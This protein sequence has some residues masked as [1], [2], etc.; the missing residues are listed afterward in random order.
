MTS[1][2]SAFARRHLPASGSQRAKLAA[3]QKRGME[4]FRYAHPSQ[5][6]VNLSAVGDACSHPET[7]TQRSSPEVNI[8]NSD[9]DGLHTYGWGSG[10]D[11]S[12]WVC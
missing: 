7:M 10:Q 6:T 9:G 11:I 3:K 1:E 4:D 8:N 12:G 5:L 2:A